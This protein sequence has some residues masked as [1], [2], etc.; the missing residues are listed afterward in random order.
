MSQEVAE[1]FI[2]E[3][4]ST[5]E[6]YKGKRDTAPGIEPLLDVSVHMIEALRKLNSNLST[7]E[8]GHPGT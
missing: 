3:L 6:T 4:T 1:A 8:S 7:S 5:I 2:S